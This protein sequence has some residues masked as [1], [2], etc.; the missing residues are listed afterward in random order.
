L[1]NNNR[2]GKPEVYTDTAKVK[3]QFSRILK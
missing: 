3:F 1:Q 2:Y